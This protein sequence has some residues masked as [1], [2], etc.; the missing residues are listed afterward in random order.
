MGLRVKPPQFLPIKIYYKGIEK[1]CVKCFGTGHLKK[2][3]ISARKYWMEYVSDL[4]F[5]TEFDLNMLGDAK[6][7]LEKW[8]LENKDKTEA[9]EERKAQEE[10]L[11][12]ARL[13]ALREEVLN[14]N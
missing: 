5:Q 11:Q 9:R 2:D 6:K 7:Y 13:E 3:C 8:R 12:S 10:A 1:R 4:M 14:I